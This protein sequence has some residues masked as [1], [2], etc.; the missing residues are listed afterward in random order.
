MHYRPCPFRVERL[1]LLCMVLNS[2][3]AGLGLF[4]HGALGGVVF[5]DIYAHLFGFLVF[6]VWDF[7]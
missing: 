4:A 7:F 1:V 5:T 3:Q 6:Q 2:L